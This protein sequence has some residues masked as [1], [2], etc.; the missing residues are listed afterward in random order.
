MIAIDLRSDACYSISFTYFGFG[1]AKGKK[2][3]RNHANIYIQLAV[4]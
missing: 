2:T 4:S 1:N 3:A